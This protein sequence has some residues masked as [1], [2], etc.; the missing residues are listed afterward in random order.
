MGS[1]ASLSVC[2]WLDQNCNYTKIHISGSIAPRVMKFG[3]GMYLDYIWVDPQGLGQRSRSW[4]KN[5]IF[6]PSA[7]LICWKKRSYNLYQFDYET[8]RWAHI[9]IKLLHF[10]LSFFLCPFFVGNTTDLVKK[11]LQKT[12]KCL[13]FFFSSGT[14]SAHQRNCGPKNIVSAA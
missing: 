14:F 3:M 11:I 7:Y 5:P 9:N 10:F 13:G 1:Y 8:G 4:D 2:M 12:H 6:S